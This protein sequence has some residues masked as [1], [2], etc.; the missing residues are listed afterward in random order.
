MENCPLVIYIRPK[1]LPF[2]V[3]LTFRSTPSELRR[4]TNRFLYRRR[5]RPDPGTVPPPA[6]LEC[7]SVTSA[8][9]VCLMKNVLP[10]KGVEDRNLHFILPLEGANKHNINCRLPGQTT[11]A[12]SLAR[13]VLVL[14]L[15]AIKGALP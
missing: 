11:P 7:A 3:P 10:D 8:A 12:P 2:S 1:I 4:P 6:G 9:G 13:S 5:H 14:V 15:V